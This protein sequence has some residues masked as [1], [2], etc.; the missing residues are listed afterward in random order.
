MRR[1]GALCGVLGVLTLVSL[2]FA[3]AFVGRPAFQ[4]LADIGVI[5]ALKQIHCCQSQV[6]DGM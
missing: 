4:F 6:F 5:A 3:A 1:L 2:G